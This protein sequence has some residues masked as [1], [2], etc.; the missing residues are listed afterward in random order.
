MNTYFTKCLHKKCYSITIVV[1]LL[2]YNGDNPQTNL[3]KLESSNSGPYRTEPASAYTPKS[4]KRV[5][6]KNLSPSN[7][8]KTTTPSPSLYKNCML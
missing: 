6:K 3:R 1:D 5:T 8:N 7:S 4:A 2:I